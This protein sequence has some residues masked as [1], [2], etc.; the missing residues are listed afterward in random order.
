MSG[1][2]FLQKDSSRLWTWIWCLSTIFIFSCIYLPIGLYNFRKY[3]KNRN[4][5]VLKKRYSIITIH[6]TIFVFIRIIWGIIYIIFTI[7]SFLYGIVEFDFVNTIL[8]I[9]F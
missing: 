1:M 2:S 7:K 9:S 3:Y 8:T 5:I 6:E 4:H